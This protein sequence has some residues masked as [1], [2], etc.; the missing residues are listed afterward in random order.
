MGD[1]DDNFSFSYE[2]FEKYYASVDSASKTNNITNIDHI[3]LIKYNTDPVNNLD[4][5][6]IKLASKRWSN[7]VNKK[8]YERY[9]KF[10][11]G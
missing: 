8:P 10:K 5:Y 1:F 9:I 2:F 3:G 7:T 4:P 11:I 6:W